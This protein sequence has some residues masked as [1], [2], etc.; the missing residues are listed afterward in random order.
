M[1]A[2]ELKASP[3]QRQKAKLEQSQTREDKSEQILVSIRNG[4]EKRQ[5]QPFILFF[6]LVAKLN[7]KHAEPLGIYTSDQHQKR[8]KE[9]RLH[10]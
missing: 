8:R 1:R 3:E 9:N 7:K 10:R 2:S 6:L 4:G 5:K